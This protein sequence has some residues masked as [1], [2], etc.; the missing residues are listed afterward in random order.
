DTS[1][2]KMAQKNL[3]RL[4]ARPG[5][6]NGEGRVTMRELVVNALRMRPDRIVVGEVRGPEAL[7]MLQAM[8]TG[9]E[10]SLGTIHANSPS[11]ALSR[12]EL[13][14]SLADASMPSHVMRSQIASSVNVIVQLG[15]FA[16]GGRRV[17][18]IVEIT[19]MMGEVV[20]RQEIFGFRR[21]GLG[22]DGRVLGHLRPT[23]LIPKFY[24]ELREEGTVL[25]YEIFD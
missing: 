20:Q 13:L 10:G 14:L 21:T 23:G 3:G 6:R 9:H 16:D 1:E 12:L 7:E 2:L 18:S 8:N 19:G 24:S 15:R 5:H 17:T 11:G 22:E 25:P 4:E